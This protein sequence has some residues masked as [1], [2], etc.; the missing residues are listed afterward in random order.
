MAQRVDETVIQRIRELR[1][2][3]GLSSKVIGMRLGL[4]E[5]TVRYY[6]R[7]IRTGEEVYE[8]SVRRKRQLIDA[9]DAENE[10]F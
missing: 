10:D 6:L 8:P 3:Y 5:R 1:E 2:R 4:S 7:A 9:E